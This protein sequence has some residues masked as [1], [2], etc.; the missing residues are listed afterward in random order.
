MSLPSTS[1]EMAL[2][3]NRHGVLTIPGLFWVALALLGRQWV[4]LMMVGVSTFRG[5]TDISL[6]LADG[7]VPWGAL[8]AQAPVLLLALAG[9]NRVPEARAWARLI[10]R[11][12]SE[13]VAVVAAF[14]FVWTVRFLLASDYWWPWPEL[15][16]ACCSLL[17]LAI[18]LSF[19]RTPYY[20]QMF[21]EFPSAA[22]PAAGPSS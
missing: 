1:Q 8:A 9:A 22:A 18:V 19:Y 6:L 14:N 3:A 13:I 7:G 21:K 11:R 12:G 10:W 2:H 16:L 17:D 15:F 4:L 20:R 5:Q